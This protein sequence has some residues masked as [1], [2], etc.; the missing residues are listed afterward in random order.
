MRQL[1]HPDQYYHIYNRGVAREK[2]F[3][4]TAHWSFFLRRMKKY[5]SPDTADIL[6]YC[7]MPNHFHF[8]IHA[9]TKDFGNAVM[10]PLLVSY[11]RAVNRDIDRVGTLFQGQYQSK[12]IET[13][14]QL[15]HLSRYIHLNPV[16]ANL[17]QHP[18]NW[19]YSSYQ[20]YIGL[21]NGTL[22]NKSLILTEFKNGSDYAS[23]VNSFQD[24]NTI[25]SLVFD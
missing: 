20:D 9:K 13:T 12:L 1:P 17:I 24:E 22:P 14:E 2:I 21:R 19:K 11:T 25:K 4:K 23:Y 7:L 8:L 10:M 5:F 16:K 3:F 18:E 6:V 15:I